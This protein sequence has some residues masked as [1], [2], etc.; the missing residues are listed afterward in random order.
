MKRRPFFPAAA[1]VNA[2]DWD[3]LTDVARRMDKLLDL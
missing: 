1:E 2:G 3:D